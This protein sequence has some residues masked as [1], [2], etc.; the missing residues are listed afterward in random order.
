L[1]LFCNRLGVFG[2]LNDGVD[3]LWGPTETEGARGEAK[4]R[5][6]LKRFAV[7]AEKFG[8]EVPLMQEAHV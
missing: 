3:V 1:S 4:I 6:S 7:F 8:I 5:P 2:F